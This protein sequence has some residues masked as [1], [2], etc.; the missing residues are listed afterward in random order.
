MRPVFDLDHWLL[1]RARLKEPAAPW[2]RRLHHWALP[3]YLPLSRRRQASVW[4]ALRATLF[5][6]R[7]AH[8]APP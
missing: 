5:A 8:G 7:A 4:P 6:G 1:L 2:W 3:V